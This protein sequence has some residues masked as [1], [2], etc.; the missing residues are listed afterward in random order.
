MSCYHAHLANEGILRYAPN[1]VK[2]VEVCKL[3]KQ[4]AAFLGYSDMQIK[5]VC[6]GAKTFVRC[7][8]DKKR[9]A[10][11]NNSI[12]RF[13]SGWRKHRYWIRYYTYSE[14]ARCP[15][16]CEVIAAGAVAVIPASGEIE[17][18]GVY[19]VGMAARLLDM[20]VSAVRR[21]VRSGEI[22]GVRDRGG[23]LITGAALLAFLRGGVCVLGEGRRGVI[24]QGDNVPAYNVL[25][26][27]CGR[28]L[29]GFNG[30]A[31]AKELCPACSGKSP[32]VDGCAVYEWTKN[33]QETFIAVKPRCEDGCYY[34]VRY[35]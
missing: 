8:R 21:L 25:S 6:D 18:S 35:R 28:Y 15:L 31:K 9:E 34:I 27:D 23:Y 2:A 4:A 33:K 30:W 19:T 17:E 20:N 29:S 12:E 10:E 22:A 26:S 5:N 32:G 13:L 1:V 16:M 14:A 7:V 3:A 11:Q 24:R